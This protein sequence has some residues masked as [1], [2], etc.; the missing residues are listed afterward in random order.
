MTQQ[1]TRPGPIGTVAGLPGTHRRPLALALI[2]TVQLMLVLDAT[3]VNVALPT[4]SPTSA[5]PRP[6]CRGS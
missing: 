4:C 1:L 5:S 3:V 6:A 2:L